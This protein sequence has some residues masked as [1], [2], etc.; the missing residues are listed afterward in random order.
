MLSA[1][2][3]LL[4]YRRWEGSTAELD[5][6][7]KADEI[8][9]ALRGCEASDLELVIAALAERHGIKIDTE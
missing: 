4:T 9:S 7:D 2:D 1:S 3:D 8:A 6:R 5:A